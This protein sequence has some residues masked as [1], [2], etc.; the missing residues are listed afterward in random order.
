M[1]QPEHI[2]MTTT[3]T[4]CSY[5]GAAF[6]MANPQDSQHGGGVCEDAWKCVERKRAKE[7]TEI[8]KE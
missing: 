6:T 2:E 4:T 3:P 1:N 8:P 5:C 7:E